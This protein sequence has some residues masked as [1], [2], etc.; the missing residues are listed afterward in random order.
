MQDR[1]VMSVADVQHQLGI[2]KNTAYRLFKEK[3]FHSFEI[4]G[5][6]YITTEDF[7]KWLTYV[8]K[9]PGKSFKFTPNPTN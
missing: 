6:F 3:S 1:M 7:A 8:K 2:G 4:Q 5:R 9:L